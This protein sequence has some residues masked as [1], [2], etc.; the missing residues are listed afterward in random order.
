MINMAT[1]FKKIKN[2]GSRVL[3]RT[4]LEI[5]LSILEWMMMLM[6]MS[7]IVTA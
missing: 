4:I 2:I 6:M 3:F 7:A 1:L 5:L